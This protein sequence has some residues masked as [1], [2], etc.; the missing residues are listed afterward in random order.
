[1]SAAI[2]GSGKQYEKLLRKSATLEEIE[3][4]LGTSTW[5]R[6]YTPSLPIRQTPEYLTLAKRMAPSEP[7]VWGTTNTADAEFTALCAI[8]TRKGPYTDIERGQVYG[9]ISGMTLFV[10]DII[11]L[12]FA[13]KERLQMN[14]EYY[15]LTFWFDDNNRYVGYYYGDINRY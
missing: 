1:M 14:Q 9:M 5:K 4:E 13:I 6:A 11:C 7:F 2:V 10:G 8:F 3:A 12:P 15:S